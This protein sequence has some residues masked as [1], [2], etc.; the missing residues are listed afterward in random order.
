M[1]ALPDNV[2]V[3]A[4][5]RRDRF[6]YGYDATEYEPPLRP[7]LRLVTSSETP[8]PFDLEVFLHRAMLVMAAPPEDP[9]AP[10]APLIPL[11]ATP[12]SA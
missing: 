8:A 9:A 1:N 3:L 4:D 6:D 7:Q 2:I 5:R 12:A 10:A 11:H